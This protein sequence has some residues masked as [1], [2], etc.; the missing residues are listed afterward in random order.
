MPITKDNTAK[1][2][3]EVDRRISIGLKVV[4]SAVVNTAKMLV[5]VRTGKLK[6]SIDAEIT[7][8]KATIGSPLDYAA[9]IER[10]NPYLRPALEAEKVFIQKVF[11][12]R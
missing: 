5:V 10:V 7:D 2:L 8:R 4:A 1:V 9:K 6:R 11:K 3:Q 12:A